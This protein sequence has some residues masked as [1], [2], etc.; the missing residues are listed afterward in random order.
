MTPETTPLHP[1]FGV[2]V[3][4]VDLRAAGR[5]H[6]YPWIRKLFEVHSLLLF[7]EQS[8]DDRS[9]IAFAEL[10]GPI[11]N[12]EK[13][14]WGK[15][16]ESTSKVSNLGEDGNVQDEGSKHVLN[17]KANQLWHTDSTFL[18]VP[19]LAN[20]IT[21]VTVP[22]TGGETELATT[23]AAL[24][25]MPDF[26]RDQAGSI[27]LRHR[28]GHSARPDRSRPRQRGTVHHVAGAALA[29]GVAE[30]GYRG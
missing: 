17:L 16:R 23:R 3:H 25:E 6:L 4:D 15:P 9:L 8:L 19:A 21:A 14:Q 12:R 2:E 30:S 28:Y 24:K 11:E 27:V 29:G 20:V 18:P 26:L 5:D 10:F 7:R 22:R 1:L 13:G